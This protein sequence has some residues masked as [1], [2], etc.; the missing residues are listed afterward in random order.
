[1]NNYFRSQFTF[2]MMCSYYKLYDNKKVKSLTR[3]VV[4]ANQVDLFS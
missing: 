1:M 2:S 3:F 4:I